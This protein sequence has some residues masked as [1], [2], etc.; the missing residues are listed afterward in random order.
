MQ[1]HSH[2]LA[3]WAGNSEMERPPDPVA[4]YP[5]ILHSYVQSYHVLPVQGGIMDQPTEMWV[6]MNAAGSAEAE[7]REIQDRIQQSFSKR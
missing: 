4:P 5:L 6:L 1:R 7:W 2:Q 3:L